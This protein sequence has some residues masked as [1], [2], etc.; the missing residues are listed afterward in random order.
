MNREERAK[1]FQ[2]FDALKGLQEELR[3]REFRALSVERR[4]L[5]EEE[6]ERISRCLNGLRKGSRIE[7]CFYDHGHYL[8]LEGCVDQVDAVGRFLLLGNTPVFFD[9]IYRLRLKRP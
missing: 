8:T 7:I 3:R 9:D 2:P 6:A 1:Q 5:S 4:C